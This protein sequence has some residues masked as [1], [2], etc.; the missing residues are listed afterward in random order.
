[1]APARD[2]VSR[3]EVP[4]AS[5]NKS[6]NSGG[7]LLSVLA[8]LI[9]I[10]ALGAAYFLY[11]QS[12]ATLAKA[13]IVDQRVKALEGQ[14]ASTG[15]E[16]SESD[17]AVRVRIKALDL[18]VR[19]LWDDRKKKLAEYKQRDN[20]IAAQEKQVASLG[21]KQASSAGQLTAL[22]AQVD[23]LAEILERADF[24]I[25]QKNIAAAKA[26]AA[27]LRKDFSALE[28]RVQSNEEW[29]ESVNVFR[30]QVNERLNEIQSPTS[31]APV[32]R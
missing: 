2:E 26:A 5:P 6:S 7:G 14:L 18:E 9:G 21:K 22:S 1:M 30:R 4:G 24:G 20:K 12:L 27:N 8:L 11:E 23:E 31:P 15:D 3:R 29:L 10:T 17:A 16:L 19:K 28:K 32:L 13:D 25:I